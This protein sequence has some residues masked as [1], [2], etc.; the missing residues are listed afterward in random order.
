MTELAE[1]AVTMWLSVDCRDA[2][3]SRRAASSLWAWAWPCW[4]SRAPRAGRRRCAARAR[5]ATRPSHIRV[6]PEASGARRDA[7]PSALRPSAVIVA[8]STDATN[9]SA[10]GRPASAR[11]SWADP[12]EARSA[13][14]FLSV[15]GITAPVL[16]TE[17]GR[18]LLCGDLA[19]LAGE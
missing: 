13:Y 19:G 6:P 3:S 10:A 16:T 17:A 4:V 8:F 5:H 14:G 7:N 18:F 2:D 12:A 11:R 9:V 1:K 15:D